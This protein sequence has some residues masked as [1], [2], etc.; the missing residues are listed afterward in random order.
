MSF[1]LFPYRDELDQGRDNSH[2]E[3]DSTFYDKLFELQPVFDFIETV[4]KKIPKERANVGKA[5]PRVNITVSFED[6]WYDQPV[7]DGDEEK[8]DTWKFL[9]GKFPEPRGF[10]GSCIVPHSRDGKKGEF[11]FGI[12]MEFTDPKVERFLTGPPLASKGKVVVEEP[13]CLPGSINIGIDNKLVGVEK[14]IRHSIKSSL[15][16]EFLVSELLN[17]N[18]RLLNSNN[19]FNW[20]DEVLLNNKMLY[21]IEKC[22]CMTTGFLRRLILT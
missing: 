9:K 7:K 5:T 19:E 22:I 17:R 1:V 11:L 6:S 15:A 4:Y 3:S 21:F 18:T 14:L 10:N 13:Y 20:K 8:I 12:P 2:K 16:A